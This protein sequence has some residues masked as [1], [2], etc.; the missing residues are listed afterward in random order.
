MSVIITSPPTTERRL[1]VELFNGED[2]HA[3]V[4]ALESLLLRSGDVPL[5]MHPS[6]LGV[7]QR[8]LRHQPYLIEAHS[9]PSLRGF[10]PLAMVK[11]QLFG[12]FLV[13]LPYLNY[14][15]GLADD[16]S[17]SS[18]LVDR[19]VALAEELRVRYLELRQEM[20]VCHPNLREQVTTKAHMRLALPDTP[21][22]LWDQLSGKV[23]NLVRKGQKHSLE[24]VWGGQDLLG[25]FYEVFCRNMR[26][27][28]TPVYSKRLFRAVLD[29]FPDRAELCVIRSGTKPAGGA[30]LLHGWGVTEVPSASSLREY[31]ST[32]ANMLMYWHLLERAVQR[33][34]RVFDFGR[35]SINGNTFR[36][37]K[38]WGAEPYPAA[39]Q[40]YLRVGQA[41]QARPD[42][43]RYDKFIRAWQKLPVWLTR[44]IG[45][46]IVRGIP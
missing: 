45:P 1:R 23:R 2:V 9:G 14:G 6:W 26:D 17:V 3:R 20:P 8:G 31:N 27:L 16:E 21:G 43:P 18:A 10:L 12:R 15:G 41:N 40:Y 5:S 46:P 33:G 39:W 7:L 42:N 22:K 32:S 13:S 30:L 11:S 44:L 4:P 35:S 38:Q 25:D 28:G 36:F 34:Q 19:A 29:Q 24:T 37:K